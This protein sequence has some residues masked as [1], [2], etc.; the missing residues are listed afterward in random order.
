MLRAVVGIL[1]IAAAGAR[2]TD[3][4]G[5]QL[6]EGQV[7][8]HPR[9]EILL[10]SRFQTTQRWHHFQ[11]L[12][13][14]PMFR[15]RLAPKLTPFFGFY[16]PVHETRPRIH[17]GPRILAGVESSLPL[18]RG[19]S[20]TTRAGMDRIFS[21]ARPAFNRYRGMARLM[22]PGRIAPYVQ[23]EWF[24]VRQ[25]F[26]STRTGG[27]VRF[28]AGSHATLDLGYMYDVRSSNWSGSRQWVLTS[29]RFHAAS[30][31]AR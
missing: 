18:D 17:A 3:L 12:R 22:R 6:A 23:N 27:G 2:A 30:E 15:F 7:F 28:L 26:H 21:D 13:V 29:I 19:L 5:W 11:Q 31:R 25:G 24:F 10:H 14:G 16:V 1:L 4:Q 8:P 20:L 9:L